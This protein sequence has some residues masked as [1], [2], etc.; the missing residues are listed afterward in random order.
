[1]YD[2]R[3]VIIKELLSFKAEIPQTPRT[4]LIQGE[5]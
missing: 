2:F 5:E 4:L 1:M 3:L